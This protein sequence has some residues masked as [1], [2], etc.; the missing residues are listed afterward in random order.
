MKI[1]QH[2]NAKRL[3][4]KNI[5]NNELE[6][7]FWDRNT[8]NDDLQRAVELQKEY[9]VK[10][11]AIHLPNYHI[12][13]ENGEMETLSL[14]E[15]I[16]KIQIFSPKIVNMHCLY[17]VEEMIKNLCLVFIITPRGNYF[18]NRKYDKK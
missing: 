11:V 1:I 3:D 14:I 4:A 12:N 13:K 18:Y 8:I 2:I 7:L 5:K 10:F 9:N 17:G 15:M 6:I 16:E